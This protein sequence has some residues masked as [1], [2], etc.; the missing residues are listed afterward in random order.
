MM[1]EAYVKP[2][3]YIQS[4]K[5]NIG[6]HRGRPV[7]C[8]VGR[9]LTIYFPQKTLDLMDRIQD[10]WSFESRSDLIQEAVARYAAE[11]DGVMQEGERN[12]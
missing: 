5:D 4:V 1:S 9:K 7:S 11:L 12:G 8:G 3:V 10:Q 6:P 2:S